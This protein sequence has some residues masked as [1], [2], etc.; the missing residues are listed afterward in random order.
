MCSG[1]GTGEGLVDKNLSPPTDPLTVV[2]LLDLSMEVLGWP[3]CFVV[4]QLWLVSHQYTVLLTTRHNPDGNC[5]PLTCRSNK[6]WQQRG[7]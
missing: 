6:L 3:S 7:G 4:M 2:L 5:T 1:R